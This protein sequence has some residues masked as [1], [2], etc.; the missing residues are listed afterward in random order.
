MLNVWMVLKSVHGWLLATLVAAVFLCAPSTYANPAL[1]QA[2]ARVARAVLDWD[3]ARDRLSQAAEEQRRL[4]NAI[5]IEKKRGGGRELERLLQASLHSEGEVAAKSREHTELGHVARRA[6]DEAFRRAAIEFR[7]VKPL[8]SSKNVADRERARSTLTLIQKMRGHLKEHQLSLA[9]RHDS[10]PKDWEKYDQKPGANDGP[11]ELR[12]KA[13]F[14]ADHRDK[15]KKKRLE[16]L[17]LIDEARQE[18]ELAR[19][20]ANFQQDA[21]LYDEN[22]RSGRVARGS[23][24]LAAAGVANETTRSDNDSAAREP[25]AAPLANPPAADNQDPSA[26]LGNAEGRGTEPPKNEDVGASPGPSPAA[27]RSSAAGS[28]SLG[29]S[30]P[31]PR[32]F[33][34]TALL[35]LEISRIDAASVSLEQLISTL[36]NLEKLDDLLAR[37]EAELSTK[38]TQL[39]QAEKSGA[40]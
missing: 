28:P 29:S 38:A 22:A 30:V 6:L 3:A 15:F 2:E 40:R 34:P 4:A 32:E 37:R 20:A 19:L 8:L 17:K 10:T 33:N 39:E 26:F 7:A 13:D 25:G 16:L 1:L 21:F 14:V 35:N 9:E 27:T 31:L 18:R 23:R 12:A 5:A 36:K 11:E 24:D